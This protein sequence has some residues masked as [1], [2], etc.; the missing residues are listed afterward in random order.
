MSGG[1]IPAHPRGTESTAFMHVADWYPCVYH[2]LSK[3]GHA[4]EL[5]SK[6]CR[7]RTLC[8]LAGVDPTDSVQ[9][10]GK[11]R[12]IDG[13]DAWPTLTGAAPN[14]GREFLPTTN[15]SLIYNS[16]WKLIVSAP[17][18]H[19]FTP[20]VLSHRCLNLCL[21]QQRAHESSNKVL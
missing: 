13:I 4:R 8:V 16:T 11:I 9:F 19:W 3:L 7:D 10:A 17:S 5:N 2:T 1:F 12:P 20:C 6:R 21:R 15:Q 18:T 14:L